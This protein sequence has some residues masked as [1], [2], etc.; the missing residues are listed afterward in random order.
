MLSGHAELGLP[1]A[2]RRH[3]NNENNTLSTAMFP[4]CLWRGMSLVHPAEGGT[5]GQT[6]PISGNTRN[7]AKCCQ[8]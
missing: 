1:P 6:C 3:R 2:A 7:M 5:S 4:N 8:I